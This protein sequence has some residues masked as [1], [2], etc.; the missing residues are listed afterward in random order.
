MRRSRSCVCARYVSPSELK[1]GRPK[2]IGEDSGQALPC[3]APKLISFLSL[4]ARVG[5]GGVSCAKCGRLP[6][7]VSPRSRGHP[8]PK[9]TGTPARCPDVKA[10]SVVTADADGLPDSVGRQAS[11]PPGRSATPAPCGTCAPPSWTRPNALVN[12]GVEQT[13]WPRPR[14]RAADPPRT[15][16][17]RPADEGRASSGSTAELTVGPWGTAGPTDALTLAIDLSKY[18][19]VCTRAHACHLCVGTTRKAQSM[20]SS[21]HS[22]ELRRLA[23][24]ALQPGFVGTGHRYPS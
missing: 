6:A 7:G 4:P 8:M 16:G 10:V 24:S 11:R 22:K 21:K 2:G 3:S 19:L 9:Q 15:A 17:E 14:T 18:P 1:Y 20:S 13:S 12:N 5:T 23:L